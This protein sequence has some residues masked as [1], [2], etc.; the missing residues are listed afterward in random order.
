[1]GAVDGCCKD[2][3][4]MPLN[5]LTW[6][7]EGDTTQRAEPSYSKPPPTRRESAGERSRMP[8]MRLSSSTCSIKSC[9]A[10]QGPFGVVSSNYHHS[11]VSRVFDPHTSI[12]TTCADGLQFL[13]TISV[14]DYALMR[15]FSFISV[16]SLCA[17]LVRS[18]FP[19][20]SCSRTI[21][22][23]CSI[24]FA[25]RLSAVAASDAAS[26]SRR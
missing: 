5:I 19:S 21:L 23:S 8:P 6:S 17:F 24:L 20:A 25:W 3:C 2:G 26:T 12:G 4:C 1:M 14:V 22:S 16:C 15:R 18:R 10:G 11:L 13:S 9:G 7:E